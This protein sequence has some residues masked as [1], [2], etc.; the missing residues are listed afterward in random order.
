MV[1]LFGR[2]LSE[3][4]LFSVV[5]SLPPFNSSHA[6]LPK[7]AQLTEG[8]GIRGTRGR[9]GGGRDS[10]CLCLLSPVRFYGIYK[11]PATPHSIQ[12]VTFHTQRAATGTPGPSVETYLFFIHL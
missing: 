8:Q 9:G 1:R 12:R 11:A 2:P 4:D 5:L 7:A 10:C 3:L 6:V